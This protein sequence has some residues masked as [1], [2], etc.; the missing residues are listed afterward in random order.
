MPRSRFGLGQAV[1]L[2]DGSA[3]GAGVGASARS[4]AIGV[5]GGADAS[6]FAS[7]FISLT[8]DLKILIDWPSD[9]AA[10]G[11][12]LAPK[13]S[14]NTAIT[15]NQCQGCKPPNLVTSRSLNRVYLPV[16]SAPT[17]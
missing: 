16:L 3:S 15:I 1:C 5:A 17:S 4:D 12:F 13:S 2:S 11:S 8:S 9:R 6:G 7:D 10:S 14:T